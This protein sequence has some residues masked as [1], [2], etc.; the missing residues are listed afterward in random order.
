MKST[1]SRTR[2]VNRVSPRV[3][4]MERAMP[5]DA[6]TGHPHQRGVGVADEAR[7]DRHAEAQPHGSN[8]GAGVDHPENGLPD[9]NSA[10]VHSVRNA[11]ERLQ[12]PTQRLRSPLAPRSEHAA[13]QVHAAEQVGTLQPMRVQGQRRGS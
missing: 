9:W 10:T 13:R 6:A 3:Q 12:D 1:N 4:Q 8:A 5:V 7:Q 2:R 11:V